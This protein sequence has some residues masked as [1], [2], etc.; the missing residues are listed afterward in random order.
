VACATC[1]VACGLPVAGL[2][3]TKDGAVG[4]GQDAPST[5]DGTVTG[6]DA[7][8]VDGGGGA[9]D[10][11]SPACTDVDASC[12]GPL[13]TGWQAI[14][15]TDGGC[16]PGFTLATLVTN[17]RIADGG[18]ACG[19]CQA[20]GT[21]DCEAGVVITSGDTCTDSPPLANTTPGTCTQASA[22]HVQANMPHATGTITCFAAS[23]AGSGASV[24]T[25][26]VCVPDCT[27][28]Y[29]SAPSRCVMAEGDVPCPTGFQ[30]F[31][32]A[33]T[34]ADPGCAPCA[35]EAGAPGTC[36]GSVT[37][38]T[39]D[40]CNNAG[41]TYDAGSCHQFSTQQD[42]SSLRVAAVPPAPSCV[43][44]SGAADPGDASLEQVR[45]ICCP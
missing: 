27:A 40:A 9:P 3:A 45:T 7:E 18:C 34:S 38:Y 44:S 37:V 23:D 30:P 1:F 17:P 21:Y 6:D 20:I 13:P 32:R 33:G 14:T 41:A 22:Q 25:L 10:T 4:P 42:F 29:C 35:C 19:P 43:P 28:D 39:D 24:D 15:I 2:G 16:N 5:G 12:L 36:G 31:A 26:G 11:G 8:T